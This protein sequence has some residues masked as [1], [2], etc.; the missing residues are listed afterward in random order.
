MGSDNESGSVS[1]SGK[2]T[3]MVGTSPQETSVASVSTGE[4]SCTH[5][6]FSSSPHGESIGRKL[7]MLVERHYNGMDKNAL[8]LKG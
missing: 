7:E 2:G 3:S 1:N 5:L 6:N 4:Q 8:C